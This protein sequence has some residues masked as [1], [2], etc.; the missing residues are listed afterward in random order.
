MAVLELNENRI[1]KIEG[2]TIEYPYC[3]HRRDLTEVVIPWHWHEELELGYIER[4]ASV[5]S[6][7]GGEYVIHQGDGFFINSNVMTTKR[8]A[9][10]GRAVLEINHIFHPVFLGGHFRSRIQTKYLD[11]IINNQKIE[12]HIIRRGRPTG[13]RILDALVQMKELQDEPNTEI[14]TRNLLAE[15]WLVLMEDIREN[16]RSG[17]ATDKEREDR[18][19]NMLVFLHS[20]FAEKLTLEQVAASAGIS[21]REALRCFRQSMDQSPMEYLAAYRLDRAK[22]LLAKTQLSI[23]DIAYQCGFSDGA[24]FGKIF[25]K[26]QGITPRAYRRKMSVT[27]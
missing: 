23:T 22:Q 16:F 27:K 15:T 26:A 21:E 8:S 1:E 4:G 11:P 6:T 17:T 14:Q 7:V 3:L 9:C 13:D 24:Y 18:L 20:N 2:M 25:K 19:R 10:P 12:V 5:I